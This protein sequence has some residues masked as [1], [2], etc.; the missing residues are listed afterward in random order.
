MKL[1]KQLTIGLAMGGIGF[2]IV[3]FVEHTAQ[4]GYW[5]AHPTA[6]P[7][8]T[9]WAE[10]GRGWLSH[11]PGRGNE[12]LHLVGNAIF[13]AGLV[14]LWYLATPKLNDK[15]NRA[16][17]VQGFHVVEHTL[18]TASFL[19]WGVARGFSTLFGALETTS[20]FVFRVW[21]HFV[22]NLAATWYAVGAVRVWW[23]VRLTAARAGFSEPSSSIVNVRLI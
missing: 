13:L 15:L 5:F 7:W 14:A 22:F 12:L 8:L 2:Q 17:W 16:L 21:W 6:A 18:L 3:H 4:L 10:A 11:D 23:Q 19:V 20:L 9:A 1:S